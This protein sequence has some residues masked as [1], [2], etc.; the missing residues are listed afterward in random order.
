MDL[1]GDFQTKP[2]MERYKE[3]FLQ[4]V[5]VDAIRMKLQIDGVI[6]EK[7]SIDMDHTSKD[8][9]A[10]MLYLHLRGHATSND[11]HKLCDA[12]ISRSGCAN[13]IKLGRKMRNDKDL[14]PYSTY[15]DCYS[16]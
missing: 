13:T 16:V 11:I 14:Q 10:E 12:M 6:P 1:V 7:L 2:F 3:K 4:V 9:A 15:V 5:N 8:E